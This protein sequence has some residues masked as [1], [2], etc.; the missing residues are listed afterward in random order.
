MNEYE[1]KV[2]ALY[3][4]LLSKSYRLEVSLEN[5]K[6]KCQKT[7]AT[8]DDIRLFYEGLMILGFWDD[9]AGEIWNILK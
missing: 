4:Y 7:D 8:A 1:A 5:R 3:Q 2:T 6:R 9:I